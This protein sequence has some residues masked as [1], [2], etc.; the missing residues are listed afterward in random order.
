MTILKERE[1]V[2]Y[3]QRARSCLHP[4]KDQFS[5]L[6]MLGRML[7]IQTAYIERTMLTGPEQLKQILIDATG[8]PEIESWREDIKSAF[9]MTVEFKTIRIQRLDSWL[10]QFRVSSS[11]GVVQE[12]EK[13]ASQIAQEANFMRAFQGLSEAQEKFI[14]GK[15]SVKETP[16]PFERNPQ[17]PG[18]LTAYDYIS[19]FESEFTAYAPKK[20]GLKYV[21]SKNDRRR[22]F[23]LHLSLDEKNGNNG[24]PIFLNSENTFTKEAFYYV[25]PKC[26]DAETYI[27]HDC[28]CTSDKP[29][30]TTRV[31]CREN[32]VNLNDIYIKP[33][34]LGRFNLH[35]AILKTLTSQDIAGFDSEKADAFTAGLFK[36]N[37]L[38][39]ELSGAVDSYIAGNEIDPV[40]FKESSLAFARKIDLAYESLGDDHLRVI[41]EMT[42][43]E[44]T[45][46]IKSGMNEAVKRLIEAGQSKLALPS[47]KKRFSWLRI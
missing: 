9:K 27:E 10:E 37:L 38:I 23:I 35:P 44:A 6:G 45:L 24:V 14:L 31:M 2:D 19:P 46:N 34:E 11:E 33:K 22:P 41:F 25:H 16:Y 40:R 8:F 32:N 20:A 15:S 28:G 36:F 26:R 39:Q 1:A 21:D 4:N 17:F 47:P 5:H 43:A 18:L 7:D 42:L 29:V 3:L 13:L 12:G 30:L